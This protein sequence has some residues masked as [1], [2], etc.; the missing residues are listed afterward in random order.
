MLSFAFDI[1]KLNTSQV[2]VLE[3]IAGVLASGILTIFHL[4]NKT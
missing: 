2:N 1:K 4:A 3:W